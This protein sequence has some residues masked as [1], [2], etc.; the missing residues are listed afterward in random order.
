MGDYYLRPFEACTRD[1]KA[2][3][4][5]CAYNAV[6]GVPQCAD[7]WFMEDLVRQHWDWEDPSHYVTSDC[8]AID[9]IFNKTAG[10][11]FTTTPEETLSKSIRAGT[12]SDCGVYYR[13]YFA[14]A[15]EEEPELEPILDRA[16]SRVFSS[17]VSLGYFDPREVNPWQNLTYDSV[18]TPNAQ[19]LA[20]KAA[21]AGI[22]LLKN[23]NAALPLC[24]DEPLSVALVGDWANATLSMQGGYHGPPPYLVSPLQ[25]LLAEKNIQLAWTSSLKVSEVMKTVSTSDVVVYVGGLDSDDESES[26][27]RTTLAWNGTQTSLIKSIA[28]LGKRFILVQTGGGQLD[29]KMWLEDDG[30]S[31]ILWVGYPGQEGGNAIADV[32]FG[33]TAPAGRLPVTQ[34]PT[35]YVT[36]PQTVL[37]LRPNQAEGNPGQTYQWYTGNATLPFGHG[38]HYTSFDLTV[39]PLEPADSS[40]ILAYPSSSPRTLH[41]D[42]TK[43]ID[44]C[45]ASGHR[46]LDQC[47]LG[48][49]RVLVTNT[50]AIASDFVALAFVRGNYGPEPR[51]HKTLASYKRLYD[52]EPQQNKSSVLTINL[53][54]LARFDEEGQRVLYPG[55][56]HVSIDTSPERASIDFELTGKPKVLEIWPAY[57][58]FAPRGS[59]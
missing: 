21:T 40:C 36:L 49:L 27:D 9:V 45:V 47:P 16:V 56:Y 35:S 25:A 39:D 54:Q 29:D 17:L 11:G 44:S 46:N 51:P 6:N 57:D 53:A 24:T 15:V 43:L 18:N 42:I 31:A 38:L 55:S 4:M 8:F 23:D 28:S 13:K 2:G 48:S 22:V 37:D 26:H 33:R 52:I 5:M 14:S 10:H 59:H 34:F 30:V 58:R 1:A 12:D 7:S 32:L 20:R 50:G 19:Q 3:S 41:L